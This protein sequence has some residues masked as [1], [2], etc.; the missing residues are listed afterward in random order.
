MQQRIGF[1][2]IAFV[3]SANSLTVSVSW[4]AIDHESKL[5]ETIPAE[6]IFEDI[7]RTNTSK[8]RYKVA[9]IHFQFNQLQISNSEQITRLIIKFISSDRIYRERSTNVSEKK[10]SPGIKLIKFWADEA[11][12][13]PN[14]QSI[15]EII[16]ARK[17]MTIDHHF[18]VFSKT[19][20]TDK[21]EGRVGWRRY[22]T[23]INT[24]QRVWETRET[25]PEIFSP[26][27]TKAK[28]TNE[29]EW[30]D[31]AA[32]ENEQEQHFSVVQS[33][34]FWGRYVRRHGERWGL[35]MLI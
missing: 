27:K 33:Y 5:W 29:W 15:C 26:K 17:Q 24:R 19:N 21:E 6:I 4:H 3:L 28:E 11:S 7:R 2:M 18:L 1:T 9:P 14:P 35:R 30:D 10:K 32:A 31:E 12:H 8:A 23:I 16:T 22:W 25:K 13:T 34:E 20:D